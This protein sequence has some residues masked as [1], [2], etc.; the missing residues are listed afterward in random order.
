V[1]TV[2]KLNWQPSGTEW[3]EYYDIT[4][5][6][7]IAFE[8][9]K[10]LLIEWL[11]RVSPKA[12]WDLGANKGVFTRLASDRGI[13]SMA[14]DIDPAAVEGN[15]QLVK[16]RK[17]KDILPLIIDLTNPSPPLGWHNRERESFSERAPA[18]MV[19]ALALIHHLAISNNV[20][21]NQIANFFCDIGRWLL[22]EFIPKGD[23][24]VQKLLQNR[25]D[26]FDHYT[27][28]DFE[29]TFR[30]KFVIHEKVKLQES[31]RYLYLMERRD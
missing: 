25:D 17:E 30:L 24:Q 10:N 16:S 29:E 19:F 6:T 26:I 7:D 9:K 1:N 11:D 12:V 13:N 21:L 18:D 31:E 2:K 15:Y 28:D 27:I 23:S 4:N 8:H 5:Y 3:G 14:F 22:I 20:P